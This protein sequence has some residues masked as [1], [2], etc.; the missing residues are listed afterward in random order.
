MADL[1]GVLLE[2]RRLETAEAIEAFANALNVMKGEPKNSLLLPQ[3]LS[4]FDDSIF[5]DDELHDV[6]AELVYYIESFED[7]DYINALVKM[8]P[9]L[10]SLARE[11][12]FMLYIALLNGG[13]S[14]CRILK[15]SLGEASA[16]QQAGVNQILQYVLENTLTKSKQKRDTYAA[17]V[18][19]ILA[20][21][22]G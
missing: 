21:E 10:L 19:L 2:N 12:L 8:T 17:K 14:Y 6:V 15:T 16:E 4:V 18:A 7:V 1:V 22:E 20:A 3:L 11:W 9:T 5:D 13:G